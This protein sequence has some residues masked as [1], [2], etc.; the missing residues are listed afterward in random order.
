MAFSA[1]DSP[2]SEC[3]AVPLTQI[4]KNYQATCT[5]S[6][7]AEGNHAITASYSGDTYYTPSSGILNGGQ[8]VLYATALAAAPVSIVSSILGLK[9]TYSAR[10]TRVSDGSPIADQT[11]SFAPNTA[12]LT[13]LGTCSARTNAQGVATCSSSSVLGVLPVLL[14]LGYTASFGGDAADS[15]TTTTAAVTI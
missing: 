2:I 4:G 15:A 1:D 9:V 8:K 13:S 7:L 6:T 12:L 10:L 11:V 5:V 14:A 3:N